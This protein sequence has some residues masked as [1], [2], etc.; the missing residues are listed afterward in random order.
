MM[1][2]HPLPIA[3]AIGAA[4][5]GD[6]RVAHANLQ[7]IQDLRSTLVKEKK[8][9]ISINAVEED[10]R[11]VS[12]WIDHAEGRNGEAISTLREIAIKEQGSSRRMEG[13]RHT[14]CSATFSK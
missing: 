4:R 14:K 3:R 6:L 13:F 11:M 8:L 7:A 1:P 12:A 2:T 10:R 5:S 9:S